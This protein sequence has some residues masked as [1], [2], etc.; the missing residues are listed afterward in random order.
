MKIWLDVGIFPLQAH[1]LPSIHNN[2]I[3]DR[4][5]QFLGLVRAEK[6]LSRN[7]SSNRVRNLSSPPN[8]NPDHC[9]WHQLS[10]RSPMKPP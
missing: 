1:H 6:H 5:M 8:Y 9:A 3:M 7:P 10:V 2:T 4:F